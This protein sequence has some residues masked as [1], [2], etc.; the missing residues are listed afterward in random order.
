MKE[1]RMRAI[2]LEQGKPA[3]LAEVTAP[4]ASD[5]DVLVR[6]EYSSLN[7][8]DALAI[9]GKAPIVRKFPMV[10]GIDFAGVVE[11]SGDPRFRPGHRALANGHGLGEDHWGGLAS[12]ARV[13]ASWL[14]PVPEPFSTRDAMCAG[15]AGYTAALAVQALIHHGVKRDAGPVLVTGASG[16]LGGFAVMLLSALGF[17][18]VASTG[19]TEEESYLKNLGASAIVPRDE[20]AGPHKPLAKARWAGVIDTVGGIILA[21]ACAAVTPRG[22]VASCGNAAG[23]DLPLTVAPFILRGIALCG[24][25]SN[26]APTTEREAAW[27]MLATSIPP[28]RM[29]VM[30]REI[31]LG[32]VISAAPDLLAGRIRGRIV[33][34][35]RN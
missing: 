19:R 15:T 34:D 30:A 3:S 18:A 23:M 28:L 1:P 13:P 22:A 27:K 29:Y 8:K 26:H 2:Y 5:G 12:H 4:P 35:V 10:A 7:Y 25:D 14:Q 11:E 17:N 21:N 16:G 24:I 20:L 33:V 6:I 31:G 32:D 9:T